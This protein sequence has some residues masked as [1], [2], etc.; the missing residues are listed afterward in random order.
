VRLTTGVEIS[1]LD[2][3]GLAPDGTA[4]D[5]YRTRMAGRDL[6]VAYPGAIAANAH[7]ADQDV[8]RVVLSARWPA[9]PPEGWVYPD[10]T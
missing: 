6:E 1:R 9:V 10:A 4:R 8:R 2:F 5:L 3:A 7:A